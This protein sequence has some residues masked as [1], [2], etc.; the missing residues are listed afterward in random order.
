MNKAD[1]WPFVLWLDIAVRIL[2][3]S[4]QEYW[5]MSLYDWLNILRVNE[6]RLHSTPLPR[7]QLMGT[8]NQ[9]PDNE[10]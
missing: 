5:S 1:E 7:D 2:G 4:P 10:E 8:T 6:D 9:F 3:L